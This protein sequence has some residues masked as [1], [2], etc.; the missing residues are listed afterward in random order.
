LAPGLGAVN[1]DSYNE[2]GVIN[3]QTGQQPFLGDMGEFIA[4]NKIVNDAERIIIEN[5][6]GA[7]YFANLAVNDY[8]DYQVNYGK[9]VIGIGQDIGSSNRHNISQARN[10]FEIRANTANF[11]DQEFFLIGNDE[12]DAGSWSITGVSTRVNTQRVLRTWRADHLGDL[13]DITLALDS[14]LAPDLPAGYIYVCLVDEAG[15]LAPDFNTAKAYE[16]DNGGAG[17]IFSNTFP[18]PDGSYVGIGIVQPTV[19]F[20]NSTASAFENNGPVQNVNVP[21]VLNFIPILDKI[22]GFTS[23]DVTATNPSD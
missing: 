11:N 10:M 19:Y 23:S 16:L 22:I 6:L 18:I 14:T 4:Y 9:E 13:G 7:K 1:G 21:I 3:N 12:T 5:Y 20:Q 8:Y 17:N 15:G 2:L